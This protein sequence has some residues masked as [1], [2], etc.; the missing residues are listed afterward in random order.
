[1]NMS[2]IVKVT[3]LKL[4]AKFHDNWWKQ[5]VSNAFSP[6]YANYEVINALTRLRYDISSIKNFWKFHPVVVQKNGKADVPKKKLLQVQICY[7][8]N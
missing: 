6:N 1:M 5:S 2:H 7:F 4:F 3:E 8:A